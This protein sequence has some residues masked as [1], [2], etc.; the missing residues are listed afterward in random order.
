MCTRTSTCCRHVAAQ[1]SAAHGCQYPS[2][3]T[4]PFPD[5]GFLCLSLTLL[6]D[7]DERRSFN[8]KSM[9]GMVA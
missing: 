2:T 1:V 8:Q 5:P 9:H 4:L 6:S 3:R 7:P